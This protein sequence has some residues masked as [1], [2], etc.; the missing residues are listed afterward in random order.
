MGDLF[1]LARLYLVKAQQ[2]EAVADAAE[3]SINRRS[4]ENIAEEYR[5][6]AHAMAGRCTSSSDCTDEAQ[7]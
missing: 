3:S 4:W 2:A 6:L 5:R 1:H 7:L